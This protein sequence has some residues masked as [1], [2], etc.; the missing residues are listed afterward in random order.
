V[1][2]AIITTL[3]SAAGLLVAL[4]T[5]LGN[6]DKRNQDRFGALEKQIEAAKETLR[7]EFRGEIG[8]LRAEVREMRAELRLEIREAGDRRVIGGR[9]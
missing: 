3:A 4:W 1:N 6:F 8:T 9:D 2:P 7:A 5:I